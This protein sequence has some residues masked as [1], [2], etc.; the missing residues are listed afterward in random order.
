VIHLITR[1]SVIG[2]TII[3][4]SLI[5]L[6]SAFNGIESMIEKLYS[7]FDSDITIR[8]AVG[9]TFQAKELSLTE[10]TSIP[11]IGLASRSIEETVV[12]KHEEKW[13]NAKLIGVDSTFLEMAQLSKHLVDG[14]SALQ[15]GSQ[16]YALIGATLL[17]NL[18]GYISE[19]GIEEQL[20]IY[21]PKRD[22]KIRIGSNPF[23]TQPIRI[24]GR[25]NY[26]REINTEILLLPFD[27][28]KKTVGYTSEITAVYLDVLTGYDV[29]EI[30]NSLQARLGDNFEVKTNYEKNELIYKTS[31]SEK[32]IVLVI[33]L[34][35]FVLAA[36][37]LVASLT[38][39]FVEK[40]EDVR[41]LIGLGANYQTIFQLFFLEGLLI[42]GK[43][44]LYGF[45][46]GYTVCV[47]QQTGELI[48][49][50]NSNGEAFPI[51]ISLVDGLL[52]FVLVAG[53]SLLF[54]YLPVR[55]LLK[56]NFRQHKQ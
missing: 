37:N 6:L 16:A 24:A 9:K 56:K 20:T 5:I 53:L 4:A 49:M 3:T 1:I 42:A 55:Y 23:R 2:I 38:M 29:D 15:K 47:A 17:D 51:N 46:L 45:I 40:K 26:N 44:I 8:S 36:F 39:L 21:A 11:G 18:G 52:I 19:N 10:L 31:K 7:D 35:I 30:K 12:L 27:F 28:A 22:S 32:V 41:T 54:S 25:I 13:V 33:L 50:P 48:T 34:F 43:G 14:S